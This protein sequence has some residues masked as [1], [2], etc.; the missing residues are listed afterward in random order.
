[1]STACLFHPAA[2]TTKR[3]PDFENLLRVLR[4]ERP[5]RPTLFEFFLNEPLDKV[6]VGD[7]WLEGDDTFSRFR[8]RMMAFRAAGY[9]YVTWMAADIWFPAGERNHGKR[10][11]SMNEGSVI[12]DRESF[13]AYPWP[14][15]ANADYS[16][17]DR[18]LD[19]LPEGMKMVVNGPCGVL[20]NMMSLVGYEDTCLMIHE[21]PQL[22]KEVFDAI[23]SRL[24]SYYKRA[25][26]HPAV[27][28][29]IS[30]DDWGFKTQPMLAPRDMRKYVFPW[31]KR[32]AAAVH[33]SGKPVILHSC[34]NLREVMDDVID[35]IQ[36]DGKHSYEDSIQRVEDAYEEYGNRIATLGGLDL[37]FVCRSTPDEIT[38]RG[39]EMLE[40]SAQRGGYALGTGNSVPDY[41]P[42][43]NYFAMLKAALR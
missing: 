26:E 41:V 37:D 21:D 20:E 22:A 35:D 32:I 42:Q 18:A 27:G 34:G 12:H 14:D 30:N 38:R 6:L 5:A 16:I 10:S 3:E 39:R 33:A 17:L 36:M 23:G 19:V 29:C 8:N 25:A 28:A 24:L 1:M 15:T 7:A 11:V 31:H 4:R 40:R 2:V 9:D 43:A 13:E